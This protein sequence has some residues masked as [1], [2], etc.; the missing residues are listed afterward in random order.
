MAHIYISHF[1]VM[2][3]VTKVADV[4]W[5]L[6]GRRPVIIIVPYV[7]SRGPNF[8]FIFIIVLIL[9]VANVAGITRVTEAL[10]VDSINYQR[11][12]R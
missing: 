1:V 6:G 7:G 11:S 3:S 2:P 10:I 12:D 8:C 9:S 5:F 4:A